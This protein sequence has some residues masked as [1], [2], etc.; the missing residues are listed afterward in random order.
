[1]E[2]KDFGGALDY[3]PLLSYFGFWLQGA[4]LG[5]VVTG[6]WRLM[7]LGAVTLPAVFALVVAAVRSGK[8]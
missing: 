8:A 4:L 5:S 7:A 3:F 2:K 1:M 6:D